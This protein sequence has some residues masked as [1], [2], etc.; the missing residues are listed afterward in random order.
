MEV[1][2]VEILIVI[3]SNAARIKLLNILFCVNYVLI[4]WLNFAVLVMIFNDECLCFIV[5]LI[6]KLGHV[7][8]SK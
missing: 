2:V 8:G 5:R 4:N 3:W 1:H 6:L 7:S